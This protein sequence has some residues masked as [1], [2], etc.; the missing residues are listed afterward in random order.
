LI[1]SATYTSIVTFSGEENGDEYQVLRP[2]PVSIE[3]SP[4]KNGYLAGF[5]D[6]NIHTQGDTQQEAFDNLRSLILDFFDDLTNEPPENLGKE[7][8]RQLAV[9]QEF[10]GRQPNAKQTRRL[11]HL[12]EI[13][14]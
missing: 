12:Q 3:L 1:T 10:I 2:I 13:E 4:E 6:A 8:K 14:S 5:F 11:E 7:P 9:L